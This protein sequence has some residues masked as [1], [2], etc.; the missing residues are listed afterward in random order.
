MRV[1]IKLWEDKSTHF[2]IVIHGA[3]ALAQ[4]DISQVSFL[5]FLPLVCS[6]IHLGEKVELPPKNTRPD[7]FPFDAFPNFSFFSPYDSS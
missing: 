1:L 7:V 4:P 2:G 5:S 3:K 6:S